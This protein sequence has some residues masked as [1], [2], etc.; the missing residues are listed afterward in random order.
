[1][2]KES[3]PPHPPPQFV[4]GIDWQR[5]EAGSNFLPVFFSQVTT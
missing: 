2:E 1:M 5:G 3:T 4:Y